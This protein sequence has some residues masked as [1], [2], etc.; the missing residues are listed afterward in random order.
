MAN[1]SLLYDFEKKGRIPVVPLSYEFKELAKI[2]ELIVNYSTGDVYIKTDSGDIVNI[3]ASETIM[4]NFAEYLENNPDILSNITIRTP[5]GSEDDIQ[6]TLERFYE[7]IDRIDKKE[8]KYAGSDS[9]GGSAN[10]AKRTVNTLQLIESGSTHVFNGSE[11]VAVDFTKYFKTSGGTI[12]GAV[13]LEDKLILTEGQ[14]Y[15]TSLPTT[16]KEG[17]LFFLIT[18]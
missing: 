9:D 14:M 18:G 15:G 17:Q 11:P 1:D 8:F 2:R 7:I 4:Q 3:C 5:D 16:G 6:A 13:T 10:S 12:S